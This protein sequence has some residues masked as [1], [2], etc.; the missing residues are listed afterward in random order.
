MPQESSVVIANALPV[1]GR[2]ALSS[3]QQFVALCSACAAAMGAAA[4]PDTA[5]GMPPDFSKQS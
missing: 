4:L 1:L 5:R 3:P 2:L